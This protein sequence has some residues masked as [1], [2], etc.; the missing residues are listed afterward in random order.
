MQDYTQNILCSMDVTCNLHEEYLRG[1]NICSYSKNV[2]RKRHYVL[3]KVY[4]QL[5][6][7]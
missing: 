6:I 7:F 3:K 5:R 4:E 1:K 2:P